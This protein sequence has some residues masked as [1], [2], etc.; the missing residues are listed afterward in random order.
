[1]CYT[2]RV[3][4]LALK[5]GVKKKDKLL[6]MASRLQKNASKLKHGNSNRVR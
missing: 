6:T 4:P 3:K 5:Q 2:S 1:V